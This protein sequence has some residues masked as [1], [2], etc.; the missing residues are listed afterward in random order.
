MNIPFEENER[1]W[2]VTNLEEVLADLNELQKDIHNH[3]FTP[4]HIEFI[5]H[6]IAMFDKKKCVCG[7]DFT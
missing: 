7:A 1:G 4:V 6:M 5:E 2:I 3:P